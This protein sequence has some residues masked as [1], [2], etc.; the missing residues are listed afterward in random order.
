MAPAG[1]P[2][3]IPIETSPIS[4]QRPGNTKTAAEVE[5]ALDVVPVAEGGTQAPRLDVP[6]TAPENAKP[7]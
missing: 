2:N 5:P 3:P 1:A 6:R 4:R 7:A